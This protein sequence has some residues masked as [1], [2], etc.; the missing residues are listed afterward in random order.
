MTFSCIGP[1]QEVAS[2]LQN[3]TSFSVTGLA[4]NTTY[5]FRIRAVNSFGFSAYSTMVMRRTQVS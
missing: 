3:A 1:W 2:P 5:I 4:P